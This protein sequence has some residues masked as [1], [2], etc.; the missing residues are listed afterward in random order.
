MTKKSVGSYI[1]AAPPFPP[2]G[3]ASGP[4]YNLWWSVVVG[5][6]ITVQ[7]HRST[8]VI[9]FV[10]VLVQPTVGWIINRGWS[11]VDRRCRYRFGCVCL[12]RRWP[13]FFRK[14]TTSHPTNHAV[15][16]SNPTDTDSPHAIHSINI[17]TH[18]TPYF[19]FEFM[20]INTC[21]SVTVM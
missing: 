13:Y 3:G 18:A 2:V 19:F 1:Y 8:Q 14:V 20:Q 12:F 10:V 16:T 21:A 7:W 11:T 15:T 9:D 4:L 17:Y 6:C 5:G